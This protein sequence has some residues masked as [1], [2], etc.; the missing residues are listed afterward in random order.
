MRPPDAAA[1]N[2]ERSEQARDVVPGAMLADVSKAFTKEDDDAGLAAPSRSPSSLPPGHFRVT[3]SGARRLADAIDPQL[4]E[5]LARAEILAPQP[6]TPERAAVGV[7]VRVRATSA[8]GVTEE[9]WYRL[10]YPEERALLSDGCS[11]D[12]P[13]GRA[14]LGARVGD[15]RELR[16][17]RGSEELEVLALVGEPAASSAS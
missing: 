8:S 11:V 13:V 12:A 6:A 5:A 16:A 4:R 17:P 3:P 7:S 1:A 2:L 9:R 14:L 15:V 10:V